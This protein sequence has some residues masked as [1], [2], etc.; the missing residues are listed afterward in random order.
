MY[1]SSY[2]FYKE[3]I[4]GIK[5]YGQN[6]EELW[7]STVWKF[8][9]F[10]VTQI[11]REINFGESKSHEFAVFAILEALNLVDLINLNFQKVQKCMKIKI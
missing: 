9:N 10:S 3:M 8:Q 1:I 6:I 7:E 5:K 4:H 2:K 11:L